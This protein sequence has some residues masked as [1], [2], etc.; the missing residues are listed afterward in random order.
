M[1]VTHVFTALA[2]AD[3]LAT[4]EMNAGMRTAVVV[5]PDGNRVKLFEDPG[6]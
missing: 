2:A 6:A 4:I 1:K 3:H 5:D